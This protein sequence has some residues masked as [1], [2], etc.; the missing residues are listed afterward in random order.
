MYFVYVLQSEQNHQLYVGYTTNLKQRLA[1]HNKGSVTSTKSRRPW[2]MIFAE[3][4]THQKD[5][6]RREKYFKTT[7]GKGAIKH[8][9]RETLK[10][11]V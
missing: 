10:I 11:D 5:A 2:K 7:P 4:Y 6:L 1:T 3:I 8:M 9:L